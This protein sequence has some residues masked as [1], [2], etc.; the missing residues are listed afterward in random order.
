GNQF[1]TTSTGGVA[2]AG[3]SISA[4]FSLAMNPATINAAT[5]TL[6]PVGAAALAPASVSYDA[7]AKVATL[8][9]AA[10]LIPNTSYQAVVTQG[11]TS[12]AG[13]AIGCAYAWSFKTAAVASTGLAPVNLG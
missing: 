11:A 5:F 10:A 12:G 8:T 2:A 13:V 7:T 1:V 6:A 3:K 4:T 9:T